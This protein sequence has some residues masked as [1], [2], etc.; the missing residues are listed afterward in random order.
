MEAVPGVALLHPAPASAAALVALNDL[1]IRNHAPAWIGGKL[2]GL[3]IAFLLP[4]VLAAA[5]EWIS[6]LF[7][8]LERR[9][10]RPPGRGLRL[11]AC[12]AAALYGAAMELVPG[13][14]VFHAAWLSA[15]LPCLSFRSGTADPT[16]LCCLLAVPLAYLH[17]GRVRRG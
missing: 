14:G 5:G 1:W 11:A 7:A 9:P 10:W 13:F 2:S 15:S 4:V 16:D 17:L 12:A 6:W 3:G 8:R